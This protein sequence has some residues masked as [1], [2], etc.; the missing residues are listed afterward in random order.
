MTLAADM[1]S[2]DAALIAA[3]VAG[4]RDALAALYARHGRDVYALALRMLG[5]A[6]DAED[7]LQ[8]VF[9]GLPQALRR[10]EERG[11]FG[12]WLRLITA[13]TA[14]ARRRRVRATEPLDAGL[15]A[16]PVDPGLRVDL[17]RAVAR[18][19][20]S[21]R[22]P[23]VLR[24]VD[25][26]SHDEIGGVLEITPANAMQRFSRACRLLRGYLDRGP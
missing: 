15:H 8:V 14:L 1:P 13:R 7:V 4:E 2:S 6:S 24:A 12:A 9:V 21:L 17:A 23:F 5:S 25:G 16:S 10:Y 26:L 22:I 18:L 11:T 3:T 19:P 20:D